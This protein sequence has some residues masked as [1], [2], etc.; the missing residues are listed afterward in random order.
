M[1][2]TIKGLDITFAQD[3]LIDIKDLDELSNDLNALK[4]KYPFIAGWD[5]SFNCEGDKE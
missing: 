1:K 5:L 4:K 3:Y 2:T